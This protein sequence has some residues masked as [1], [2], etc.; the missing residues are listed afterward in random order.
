M[1][2]ENI[3]IFGINKGRSFNDAADLGPIKSIKKIEMYAG[4]LL[5]GMRTT[6]E[7]ADGATKVADHLGTAKAN[8]TIDFIP[9]EVLLGM[10]GKTS[11]PGYFDEP[12]LNSLVFVILDTNSGK[13]RVA[14]PF[15]NGN[16]DLKYD[17]PV[18]TI[19]GVIPSF[20]GLEL[21]EDSIPDNALTLVFPPDKVISS[22]QK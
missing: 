13:V 18:F 6:Y 11:L 5:D 3:N 9:G 16:T 14:G 12:Y 17:G 20:V 1:A 7:M 21:T 4:W 10:T 8:V 19:E 15:G 22:G 2:P